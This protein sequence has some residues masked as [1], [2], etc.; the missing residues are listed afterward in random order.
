LDKG[1]YRG[2]LGVVVVC[3]GPLRRAGETYTD[4]AIKECLDAGG[5]RGILIGLENFEV[6]GSNVEATFKDVFEDARRC[7]RWD[8]GIKAKCIG[9]MGEFVRDLV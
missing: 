1:N 7:E 8:R 6:A 9:G 4:C 3:V 2:S 5:W